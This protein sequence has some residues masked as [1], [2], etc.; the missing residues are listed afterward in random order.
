MSACNFE[1]LTQNSFS[2]DHGDGPS[3]GKYKVNLQS[4]EQV[5]LPILSKSLTIDRE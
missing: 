3:V 4:F 5:S 2:L 1:Q